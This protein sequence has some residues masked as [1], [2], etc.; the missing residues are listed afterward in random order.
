M[1]DKLDP[2]A[3]LE[4]LTHSPNIGSSGPQEI[5]HHNRLSL[6]QKVRASNLLF[7]QISSPRMLL[8]SKM[9]FKGRNAKLT[10][11][12]FENPE[13]ETRMYVAPSSHQNSHHRRGH[14]ITPKSH[15]NVPPGYYRCSHGCL[16]R[17]GSHAQPSFNHAPEGEGQGHG[18]EMGNHMQHGQMQPGQMQH[19]QMQPGQMQPGQMQYG[20]MQPG[21]MQYGQMQPGQM[22]PGQ[23]Y[24]SPMQGGYSNPPPPKANIGMLANV[25]S[26]GNTI[27]GAMNQG[28]GITNGWN[29][30]F[31]N[32]ANRKKKLFLY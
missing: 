10:K 9:L 18:Q 8:L 27:L 12:K 4:R 21:Q 13:R 11:N 16:C 5:N 19:G 22:Q 17:K 30:Q 29:N 20:Q 2:M 24:G 14:E 23:M 26:M 3:A 6:S 28:M 32:I 31:N 15:G 1:N 25:G 7:R